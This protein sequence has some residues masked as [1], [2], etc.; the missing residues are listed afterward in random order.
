MSS[1]SFI[2]QFAKCKLSQIKKMIATVLLVKIALFGAH[3]R[4]C[5]HTH[6]GTQFLEEFG[7]CFSI[8]VNVTII[9]TAQLYLHMLT[10]ILRHCSQQRSALN[11]T[12]IVMTVNWSN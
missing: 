6:R 7:H 1:S 3:T 9:V 4:M 2:E 5:T 10:T 11:K 8:F 12:L